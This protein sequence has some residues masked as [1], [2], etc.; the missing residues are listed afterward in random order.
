MRSSRAASWSREHGQDSVQQV[1]PRRGELRGVPEGHGELL[2]KRQPGMAPPEILADAPKGCAVGTKQHSTGNNYSW[3]GYEMHIGAANGG[4]PVSCVLPPASPHD[5]QV[6]ISLA[7]MTAYWVVN[8][9]DL[10]DDAGDAPEIGE[11]IAQLGRMPIIAAT[12]R[13]P[14]RKQEMR[15]EV[16]ARK[17]AG[18]TLPEERRFDERT[19]VERVN[20]RLKDSFER[21]AGKAPEQ[22]SNSERAAKRQCL[23]RPDLGAMPPNFALDS[24]KCL[25]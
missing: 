14:K 25:C 11:Y 23:N 21:L 12:H 1:L 6:A 19:T 2:R 20:R 18:G 9:H 24:C 13:S 7:A 8:L 15:A 5:S 16:A 4:V 10:M 3:I 22:R 17:A